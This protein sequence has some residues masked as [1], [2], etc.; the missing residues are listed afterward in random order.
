MDGLFSFYLRASMV[1]SWV[2]H[3]HSSSS[4]N[5]LID[6][7]YILPSLNGRALPTTMLKAKVNNCLIS[8]AI[9]PPTNVLINFSGL[10]QVAL[11]SDHNSLTSDPNSYPSYLEQPTG[12]KANVSSLNLQNTADSKENKGYKL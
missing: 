10:G 5:L 11:E 9:Y 3:L 8:N 2:E 7:F 6:G 12:D 1:V 4:F